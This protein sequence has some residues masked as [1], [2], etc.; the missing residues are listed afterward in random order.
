MHACVYALAFSGLRGKQSLQLVALRTTGLPMPFELCKP[1]QKL[2]P[3]GVGGF[4]LAFTLTFFAALPLN[5]PL[6]GFRSLSSS[7]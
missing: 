1:L 2:C 5:L 6:G 7:P 3:V 4:R